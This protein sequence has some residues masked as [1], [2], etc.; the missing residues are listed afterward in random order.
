MIF[1]RLDEVVRREY[2]E[3]TRSALLD[4]AELSGNDTSLGSYPDE[5]TARGVRVAAALDMP[6][7]AVSRVPIFDYD[8]SD[9][10]RQ[11]VGY[12]PRGGCARWQRA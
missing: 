7:D 5:E 9:E 10:D 8:T 2:A 3:D 1:N 4:A 12:R 6:A 11:L